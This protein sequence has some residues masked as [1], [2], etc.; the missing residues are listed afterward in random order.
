M[1]FVFSPLNFASSP[2]NQ[3][4]REVPQREWGK[5]TEAFEDIYILR[6]WAIPILAHELGLYVV[7]DLIHDENL[8]FS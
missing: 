5:N 4:L 2:T 3:L 6:N 7:K 1:G 8:S